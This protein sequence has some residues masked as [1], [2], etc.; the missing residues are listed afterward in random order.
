MSA[1]RG[2]LRGI[3]VLEMAG[4]GPAP[5]ACM[6]LADLGADVLRLDRPAASR[7]D[8]PHRGEG[9]FV[10]P[11]RGRPTLD[12]DLKSNEGRQH[13]LR[14][15][16]AADVLVEG[17][18]PGVMERLGLGPD[19]C[20]HANPRLVYGRMTGWGQTGPLAQA[21]GHDINYIGLAGALHAIGPGE[22]PVPPLNLV[23]DLGGGALYLAFGV[24]AALLEARTS[25]AGQVVDAAIVDGSLSLMA[26]VLGRH[27]AGLWHD[28]RGA[29]LLDGGTPW[30]DTYETADGGFVAVGAIEPQFWDELRARLDADLPDAQ[31]R[32]ERACW[33]ALRER[34]AAIFR[35]RT[36]A[37]WAAQFDRTD[38]CV[39][40]VLTLAELANHPHNRA[41]ENL[42][43][44]DGVIQPAP[45]PRFSR[46]PGAVQEDGESGEGRAE[47]WLGQGSI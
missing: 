6:L 4:I 25:G 31:Q 24:L 16:G 22:R 32:H 5:F 14:L 20:L 34:L 26:M 18:R 9:K 36:R 27:A 28:Q 29:N 2:P 15:A 37:E 23:G 44:K 7:A 11:Q 1:A 45:A 17:F 46:T 12:I 42:F 19:E 38:A 21:A 47:R 35:T 41:R 39:T 10:V 13:A 3:R 33:P 8:A 30:Y 43:A 40:P